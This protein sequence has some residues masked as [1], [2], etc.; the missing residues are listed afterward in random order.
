MARVRNAVAHVRDTRVLALLTFSLM[1]SCVGADDDE[2]G[3]VSF[4]TGPAKKAV[5]AQYDE[6]IGAWLAFRAAELS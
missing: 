6:D 4:G 3:S 1:L 5:L 2:F